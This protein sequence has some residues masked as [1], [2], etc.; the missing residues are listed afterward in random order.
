MVAAFRDERPLEEQRTTAAA[1]ALARPPSRP[2]S[3]RYSNLGYVVAGAAIERIT[4]RSWENAVL[5]EVLEPLGVTSAGFGAPAGAGPWGH[6]T[7]WRRRGRGP[8]VDP[9]ADGA[10]NP[11]V[12]GPAGRIHMCLED[13]TAF[14]RVF[15]TGGGTL[16]QEDSVARLTAPAAGRGPR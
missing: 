8:S 13:W 2:G 5:T 15:I 12:L 4:G 9:A 3:L 1:E 14:V 10:D 16:L 11:A 7:R 6:R